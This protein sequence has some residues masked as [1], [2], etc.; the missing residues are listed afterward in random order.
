MS[1]SDTQIDIAANLGFLDKDNRD[2][3]DILLV[4]IDK[5]VYELVRSLREGVRCS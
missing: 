3:L 4:R 2:Q 5:M 1:E